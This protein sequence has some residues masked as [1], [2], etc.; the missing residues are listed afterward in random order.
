MADA[1]FTNQYDKPKSEF[2]E[3]EQEIIERPA[4]YIIKLRDKPNNKV[5]R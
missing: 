4:S 1:N 5:I 2:E 3:N